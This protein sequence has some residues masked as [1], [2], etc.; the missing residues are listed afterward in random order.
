MLGACHRA[1]DQSC[2]CCEFPGLHCSL[3]RLLAAP[4]ALST[5]SIRTA[6]SFFASFLWCRHLPIPESP[7]VVAGDDA[8][9]AF[10]LS[11][12]AHMRA[13]ELLYIHCADGNGRTGT[14]AALLLGL[15]HGISSSEALDMAQRARADR[16]GAGGSCPE[17]HEQKMQVHRLLGDA[18][19]RAAAASVAPRP[20]NSIAADESA[21]LAATLAKIRVVLARRGACSLVYLRRYVGT[22]VLKSGG[23]SSS[24]GVIDRSTFDRVCADAEWFLTPDE[25]TTLWAATQAA[26]ERELGPG[27]AEHSGVAAAEALWRLV[28]GRLSERRTA[29]VHDLFRRLSGGTGFVSM[30]RLASSFSPTAH[31]DVTAG[32]RTV[33]AVTAEFLDT[34]S[35]GGGGASGSGASERPA[36]SIDGSAVQVQVSAS[37]WEAY[38]ASLS[39][40]IPDDAL[41]ELWLYGSWLP[42]GATLHIPSH[43][44]GAGGG[45]G[46]AGGAGAFEDDGRAGVSRMAAL[47]AGRKD[48]IAPKVT[49]LSHGA[50]PLGDELTAATLT[51]AY[52]EEMKEVSAEA[53]GAAGAGASAGTAAAAAAAAAATAVPM[54]TTEHGYTYVDLEDLSKVRIAVRSLLRRSGCGGNTASLTGGTPLGSTSNA[55]AGAFALAALAGT[56]RRQDGLREGLVSCRDLQSAFGDVGVP[57][58]DADAALVFRTLASH[59]YNMPPGAVDAASMKVPLEDALATLRERE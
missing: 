13:G 47:R 9:K 31:P 55:G 39:P 2:R 41:F 48:G 58:P 25:I 29:A 26:S 51:R 28:R 15:A 5:W 27:A 1:V 34:F 43:G 10:A 49:T 50:A 3:P 19:F 52:V 11:L 7:G 18:A 21:R 36:R 45:F 20:A 14:L 40:A 38:Y 8:L 53:S 44:D 17:T 59:I 42:A 16:P 24:S 30:T 37:D 46:A 32:R 56:L 22:H 23:G 54:S 33:E 57:L 35:V 6:L 12:V 4:S